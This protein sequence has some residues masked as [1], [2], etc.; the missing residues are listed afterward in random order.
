MLSFWVNF[1]LSFSDHGCFMTTARKVECAQL[2]FYYLF[3]QIFPLIVDKAMEDSTAF[4]IPKV[5]LEC[6][7]EFDSIVAI[8]FTLGKV[9]GLGVH[10]MSINFCLI[11]TRNQSYFYTSG[12][13]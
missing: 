9:I 6:R 12:H 13:N 3:P 11:S 8:L 7:Q 10:N 2:L 4:K 1:P 5:L